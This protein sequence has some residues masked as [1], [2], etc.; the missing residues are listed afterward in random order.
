MGMSFWSNLSIRSKV[1][2]AFGVVLVAAIGLGVFG[3][4]QT[5]EV[6]SA[7][8]D[9][10]DNWLPSTKAL[11]QFSA[12]LEA[13]R[14]QELKYVLALVTKD[15]ASIEVDAIDTAKARDAVEKIRRD[16]EKLV[17]VGTED[18][19]LM[20]A[21]D[22][23]WAQCKPLSIKVIDLVKAGDIAAGVALLNGPERDAFLRSSKHVDDDLAFNA[24]EGKKAADH[25]AAVYTS[26]VWET[27]AALVTTVA[28]AVAASIAIISGVVG[29]IRRTTEVVNRLAAGDKTIAIS[30]TDRGDEV[31]MLAR[32]LQIFKDNMIE[33]D[34]LSALQAAEDAAK[35]KRAQALDALT[36]AFERTVSE[37]AQSV[38]SAATEMEATAQS[39]AS[40][41]EQTNMQATAVA[42][43]SEE[44][45]VNVQTVATATEELSSSVEEIGRQVTQSARI[46]GK[47]VA[48]ARS[49]DSSVQALAA[50][51]QKIGDVVTLIQAIA[52][53]TNLL[54]LNATIEAARAGEAG[55]GFAVVAS[56]VKSLANQT[57][58]AT[59]DIAGQ[60]TAVQSA[61]TA[62]VTAIRA[63][64]ATIEEI[65][66]IATSIASAVEEQSAATREI[67]RNV[68]EAARGT[69]EMSSNISGVR[70]A[71]TATG[72]AASQ[73]LSAAGGLSRQATTLT[74]EVNHFIAGVKAA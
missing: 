43:G 50:D 45:S 2:T 57:A 35:V 65:N 41:A 38:T 58:K 37:L 27:I 44:T 46:A 19:R 48:D 10:R 11:G 8:L 64:I 53:Q 49:A 62:T 30:E 59:T 69:Q 12:S 68:Q 32:A 67:A 3:L 61:T 6:N 5:S 47:A 34:R 18:E 31:G 22:E 25:G 39:M 55:K 4:G 23:A 33:A 29:P 63:V 66:D 70:E 26:S 16:Y 1:L 71:S 24:D 36:K 17:A 54:A 73:V 42:A 56:E 40:I 14:R 20:K 51:A 60:I 72:A 7:A 13:M 28:I 74:G 15:T 21:F 9:I 52:G